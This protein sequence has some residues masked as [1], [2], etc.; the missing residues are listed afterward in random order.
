MENPWKTYGKPMENPW[1]THGKLLLEEKWMFFLELVVFGKNIF[2][3]FQ[4]KW[5]TL[6]AEHPFI[7]ANS[8]V[9]T[10]FWGKKNHNPLSTFVE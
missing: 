2:R 10:N 9:H 3:E 8:I 5:M 7:P 6:Q 1:K 4:S